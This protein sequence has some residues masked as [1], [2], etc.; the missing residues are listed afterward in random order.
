MRRLC[1]LFLLHAPP[2][3]SFAEDTSCAE[4]AHAA[5]TPRL[6]ELSP[7]TV[8]R[9]VVGSHAPLP[10]PLPADDQQAAALLQAATSASAAG[11]ANAAAAAYMDLMELRP[12]E[13]EQLYPP[14]LEALQQIYPMGA[15]SR[16]L[17]NHTESFFA[18]MEERVRAG[19]AE[20]VSR[21]PAVYLLR[22]FL[23]MEEVAALRSVR[24]RLRAR[25]TQT[26]ALVCFQHDSYT[27]HA[28]LSGKWSHMLGVPGAG[29][30]GCLTQEASRAVSSIVPASESLSVYR[31]ETSLLDEIELR[32]ER[33]V[34]LHALHAHRWQLLRYRTGEHYAEHADCTDRVPLHA[35]ENRMATLLAYL[36][37]DFEGGETEFPRLGLKL[38]PPIGSALVFYNYKEGSCSPDT[39][40]RSN[41]ILRG[42]KEVL[43]RWYAYPEQP[44]LA[45][46]PISRHPKDGLLPFQPTIVCDWTAS[47]WTNV[48]C[49]WYNQGA[50]TSEVMTSPGA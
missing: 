38:K 6:P 5:E 42:H 2:A 28:Q 46:R 43:Q 27:G 41:P 30:R 4:P 7:D 8:A 29:A 9:A 45:A 3:P 18:Q 1:L 13:L 14:L 10:P 50:V 36:T 47:L 21:Q 22:D 39:I 17:H 11:D 31:G 40:H 19:Q 25:W 48:S 34:G 24:T 20:R 44:F 15:A 49:R 32:V 26:H 35:S 37:D 23:S 12:L 16:T 33:L